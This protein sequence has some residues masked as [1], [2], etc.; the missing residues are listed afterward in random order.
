MPARPAPFLQVD[1]TRALKGAQ[2]A[3]VVTWRRDI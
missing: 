1:V 2:K 3:G